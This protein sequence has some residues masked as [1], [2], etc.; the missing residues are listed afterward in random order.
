MAISE[1]TDFTDRGFQEVI[2]DAQASKNPKSVKRVILCSGKVYY[3][4]LDAKTK[5]AKT[6]VA[7]VRLEQIYPWP[8]Q[9]LASILNQYGAAQEIVWAQEEPRN[10]GAWGFVH[11]MWMGG[12]ADFSAQVGNRKIR[13]AG[14]EATPSPAVGST[15]WHTEQQ[16]KI[17]Q[18]ALG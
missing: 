8:S 1:L 7:L 13:Y 16:E 11:G 15:K 5:K 12:L 10:M 18:E 4:L 3:D 17:M 6:D 2:D 14:R 9:K